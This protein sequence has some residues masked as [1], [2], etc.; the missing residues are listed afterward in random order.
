MS[1]PAPCFRLRGRANFRSESA[2]E[3]SPR[4][5]L[6]EW[7]TVSDA[8][9]ARGGRVVCLIPETDLDLTGMPYAAE[10]GHVVDR[11]GQ[12]SFLLPNMASPHRRLERNV[13]REAAS[14]IG[15]K[16]VDIPRGIWEA[17]GDVA[18]FRGRTLL[19]YGGRT[20]VAGVSAVSRWF[21]ED[22]LRVEI[23][24]PAFHGNMAMLPLESAD[25]LVVCPEALVGDAFVRLV[26][27][28]GREAIVPVDLDDVRLYATNALAIGRELIVP[29]LAPQRLTSLGSNWGYNIVVV[30]MVEL[31]DKGG[32]GP[33]CLVSRARLECARI[34]VP[35]ELD[36]RAR[37]EEIVARLSP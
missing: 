14:A 26:N 6:A 27:A 35:H 18:E 16:P 30:K 32:G 31:C 8:I 37:R 34:R 13:W 25:K 17:Q 5:A 36:F 23:R 24:L 29:H 28:F 11:D 15:L 21:P 1:P 33:R 4:A 3:V 10:S 22:A 19:T 2:R 7:L 20:D 9:E 12:L